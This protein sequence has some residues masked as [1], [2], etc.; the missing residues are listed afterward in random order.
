RFMSMVESF[1]SVLDPSVAAKL[2]GP[3]LERTLDARWQEVCAAWPA[4]A[5][6]RERF[7]RFLGERVPREAPCAADLEALHTSELYLTCACAN[8][9]AEAIRLLEQHYFP[10]VL[11]S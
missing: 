8:W 3:D 7:G 10:F 6:T 9:D 2:S 11:A 1:L 4:I 5:V